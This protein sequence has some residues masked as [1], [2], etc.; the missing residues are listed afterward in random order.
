MILNFVTRIIVAALGVVICAN[1]AADPRSI[2]DGVYTKEQAKVGEVLYTQQ[3]ILCH[4][5]KYFRPVLKRW[6]G[7]AINVLFT[8]MSTSMP[9]NNPGFL[10]EKEY[11]D[12][13]AYVLSLSRYTAGDSEL[14]YKDGALDDL[15]VAARQRK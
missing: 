9:E 1:T 12:I 14:E 3:C 6:E 2:N 4:D 15:I 10:S 13:L 11:V 5:K 7:Q 8:V